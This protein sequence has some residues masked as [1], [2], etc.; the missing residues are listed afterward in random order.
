MDGDQ[1]IEH[2]PTTLLFFY[3]N[4]LYAPYIFDWRRR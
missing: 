1:R 3:V 2:F 4:T